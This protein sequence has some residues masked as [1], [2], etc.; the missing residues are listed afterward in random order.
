[1]T[2][3]IDQLAEKVEA[4]ENELQA[5]REQRQKLEQEVAEEEERLDELRSRRQDDV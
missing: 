2:L 4:L 5:E 3:T 1:M